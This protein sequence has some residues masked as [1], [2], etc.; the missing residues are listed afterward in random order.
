MRDLLDNP[1]IT[2]F[3]ASYPAGT[4][5]FLEG[6]R[7]KDLYILV[8][9]RLDI[10]KG[11]KKLAEIK[12][13]GSI[14]GEMAFLAGEKRT[15]TV[16]A[17]TAVEAIRIP[18]DQ[19]QELARSVPDFGIELAR[20]IADRLRSTTTMAYGF[21]EFCDQ[22]P[23]AVMITTD[24]DQRITAW[25]AAAEKLYGRSAEEMQDL[26]LE[27]L[28]EERETY[29]ILQEDIAQRRPGSCTT[30]RI[31]LP[32]GRQRYVAASVTP[33]FDGHYN[34]QGLLFLARDVTR[35]HEMERRYRT[36]RN[37]LVPVLLVS[38]L[39]A[40]VL[41]WSWPRITRG[42][43]ILDYKKEQFRQHVAT[44]F[45]D[46]DQQ[47]GP[48]AGDTEAAGRLMT[49]YQQ[50]HDLGH[51]GIHGILLLNRN[52]KVIAVATDTGNAATQLL[53]SSYSA[54]RLQPDRRVSIIHLFRKT[55]S[56]PMGEESWELVC[57]LNKSDGGWI[58][59]QLD[60]EELAREFGLDG[61]SLEKIRFF[62]N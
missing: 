21:K 5:I 43:Q 62:K 57:R 31:Q 28:Y 49:A 61:S 30:G 15:A 23:D 8:C 20:T 1:A 33:L 40:G 22:L 32:D 4:T 54:F 47:L 14:F 3:Q 17:A 2:R 25:N 6:D 39:L 24:K 11:Q 19:I 53:G 44:F 26:P 52:K 56:R 46:L 12:E 10:F 42:T 27:K 29:S 60:I 34:I 18:G 51:Y 37:W 58:S 48:L 9:G 7:T 45:T 36:I 41:L 16:R 38:V 55:A 50:E 13:P 59:F 35:M